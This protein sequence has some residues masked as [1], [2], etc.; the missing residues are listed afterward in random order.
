MTT[1]QHNTKLETRIHSFAILRTIPSSSRIEFGGDGL[2]AP[3]LKLVESR[4]FRS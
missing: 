1:G 3:F 4:H 2:I